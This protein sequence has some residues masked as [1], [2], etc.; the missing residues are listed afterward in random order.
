MPKLPKQRL[1]Q[2]PA[3]FLKRMGAFF[4]DIMI[5]NII[6]FMSFESVLKGVFGGM[7]YSDI[8]KMIN[9]NPDMI[10]SLTLIFFVIGVL[11][12]TYF[13]YLEY[14]IGQTV[15]MSLFGI[16]VAPIE[17]NVKLGI[18]AFFL[19]NAYAIPVF[20]FMLL[21]IIDPVYMFFNKSG[22]R[23]TES[24]SKTQTVELYQI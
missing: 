19:R 2:G 10:N 8:A 5:L 18:T 15:G 16:S 24:L 14:K 1:V 21:W 20:P 12:I 22:Q 7:E 17:K 9:S 23:F 13:S 6:V 4:I 3:S 11:C